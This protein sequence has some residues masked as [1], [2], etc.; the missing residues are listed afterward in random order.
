MCISFKNTD[1]DNMIFDIINSKRDKSSFIKDAIL[2]YIEH[3][4]DKKI[5]T[6]KTRHVLHIQKLRD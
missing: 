2:F 1:E 5:N 3:M 4:E 6:V